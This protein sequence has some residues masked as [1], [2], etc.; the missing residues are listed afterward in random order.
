V[1]RKQDL[2]EVDRA[3]REAGLS[4]EQRQQ[5][6]RYLHRSKEKGD[7]GHKNASGDYTYEELLQKAREFKEGFR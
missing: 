6:G 2:K 3:A 1:G 4:P 5:F 7:V